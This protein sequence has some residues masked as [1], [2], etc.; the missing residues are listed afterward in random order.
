MDTL[1]D[2]IRKKYVFPFFHKEETICMG[3]KKDCW[4]LIDRDI[5]RLNYGDSISSN[6]K[7]LYI[8]PTISN[9]FKTKNLNFLTK[10]IQY[11]WSPL[12]L[13][14][15][16]NENELATNI[17]HLILENKEVY[18]ETDLFSN[19]LL[20]SFFFKDKLKS[21]IFIG[22]SNNAGCFW[23]KLN[24]DIF[25]F[26]CLEYISTMLNDKIIE[27]LLQSHFRQLRHL[28]V[29]NITTH[30]F[31]DVLCECSNLES[32]SLS[33]INIDLNI[34]SLKQCKTIYI[35]NTKIIDCN[36]F[37]ENQGLEEIILMGVKKI[38]NIQILLDLPNLKNLKIVNCSKPITKK[39]KED[40]I[41]KN[42]N[43][44]DI[45]YA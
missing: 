38:T 35:N 3:T 18:M 17:E 40:F 34:D 32:L 21:L 1:Q 45:D 10:N 27:F 16:L 11:L 2:I 20:D 37:K 8:K 30:R 26:R 13:L 36:I 39:R 24:I 25:E 44:L 42:F 41:S 4:S 22:D 29:K 31:L 9:L 5:T 15:F 28:A 6:V 12:P 7:M 19:S 23:S 14:K 33:S 43:L